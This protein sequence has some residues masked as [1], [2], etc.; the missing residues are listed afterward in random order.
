MKKLTM[1]FLS[2][3][4]ALAMSKTAIADVDLNAYIHGGSTLRPLAST[5]YN[6]WGI[7]YVAFDSTARHSDGGALAEYD[8]WWQFVTGGVLSGTFN[9]ATPGF[10]LI[11]R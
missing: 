9:S 6:A 8:S 3:L 4:I 5:T 2:A 11:L 1:F 7:M 10:L